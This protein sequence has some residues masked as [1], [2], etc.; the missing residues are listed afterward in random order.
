[1]KH[2]NPQVNMNSKHEISKE[3]LQKL[4]QLADV[5][6]KLEKTA[7]KLDTFL[8]TLTSGSIFK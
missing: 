3:D 7:E 6:E 1:M 2:Q 5:L 8:V 4:N